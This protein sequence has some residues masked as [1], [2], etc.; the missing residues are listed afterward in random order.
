MTEQF[1]S[2]VYTQEKWK[3]V[4]TKTCT[5]M[6]IAALFIIAPE[7]TQPKCPT[8]EWINIPYNRILFSKKQKGGGRM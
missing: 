5:Q 6:F 1:Q 8:D 7:W 2:W 3:Y 4:L